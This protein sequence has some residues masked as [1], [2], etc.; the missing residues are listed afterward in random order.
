M[1]SQEMALRRVSVRMSSPSQLSNL[2]LS[3]K[4]TTH[5]EGVTL[6]RQVSRR[7][8]PPQPLLFSKSFGDGTPARRGI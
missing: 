4:H 7:S 3:R 6:F 2:S 8:L 5:D 1:S